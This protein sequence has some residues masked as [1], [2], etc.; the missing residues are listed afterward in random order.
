MMTI[1]EAKK[2]LRNSGATIGKVS[3]GHRVSWGRVLSLREQYE[4]LSISDVLPVEHYI[5]NDGLVDYAYVQLATD[6]YT[7]EIRDNTFESKV[8]IGKQLYREYK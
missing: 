7:T 2:I 3:N 5:D 8:E 1:T 6:E 4:G